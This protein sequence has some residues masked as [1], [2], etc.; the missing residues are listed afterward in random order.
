MY[1]TRL[2]CLFHRFLEFHVAISWFPQ[3][4]P[5]FS[6]QHATFLS[7]PPLLGISRCYFPFSSVLSSVFSID[8]NLSTQVRFPRISSW[9]LDS[10]Q[11]RVLASGLCDTVFTLVVAK[12]PLSNP[13]QFFDQGNVFTCSRV[14]LSLL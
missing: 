10:N 8:V 11:N 6:V 9:L 13:K 2:F 14:C 12:A 4:F 7:F 3:C 5:L 1:S